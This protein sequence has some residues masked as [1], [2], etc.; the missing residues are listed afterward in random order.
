M[1][2]FAR[3]RLGD[4]VTPIQD[5][6]TDRT[7]WNFDKYIAGG[8]I[9]SGEIRIAKFGLIEG[10]EKVIGPAFHMRF[11][12]GHV[13]Y[14]T[15][16]AYLRKAGIV[17]FEGIC[18]NV[19]LV[20]QANEEKLLQSLL[21]FVLQSEDF[22]QFAISHSTGS[23]NPFVKWTDLSKYR[24]RIPPLN[25]QKKISQVLWAIENNVERTEK[26]IEIAEKF[27]IGLLEKLLTKGI[28][29]KDLK[30]TGVGKIP[31]GWEIFKVD[32]V[33][34]T[35]TVGIVIKPASYYVSEGVPALRSLNIRENGINLQDLVFISESDNETKLAKS[36]LKEGDVL[37]VRTGYPG[38]ACVVPRELEGANCIDL[39]IARPDKRKIES[40]YL[41]YIF[42]SQIVKEQ[43]LAVQTGMAQKHFNISEAKK[44]KF[45]L[46]SLREQKK[47]VMILDSC[48]R[49]IESIGNTLRDLT[50]LR[51]KLSNLLLSGELILSKGET[52]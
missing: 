11:K 7:K 23:T 12:P 32:E 52:D 6:F 3:L 19:T 45:P 10:N 21:P 4:V 17:N 49:F 14:S 2:D 36:R 22:V 42:N 51:K 43:I 47:I 24:V 37:I 30:K 25:I 8:H 38:T 20:L 50:N 28:E 15:R 41:R 18:S 9:D 13:L 48:N 5:R 34:E 26:F 46:P 35:L 39:I 31:I 29:H 1:N 16:R 40:D 27:K 33:C 44:I